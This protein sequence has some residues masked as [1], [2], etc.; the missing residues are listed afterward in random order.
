MA[1][2]GSYIRWLACF[3]LFEVQI[4]RREPFLDARSRFAAACDREKSVNDAIAH[5]LRMGVEMSAASVGVA[6]GVGVGVVAAVFV[7]RR[8]TLGKA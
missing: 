2:P 1:F 8:G 7:V 4:R 3:A 5:F 6:A